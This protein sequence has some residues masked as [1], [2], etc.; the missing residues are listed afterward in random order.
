MKKNILEIYSLAVCFFAVVCFVF[1]AAL[2]VYD[3]AQ[4]I[5][6]GFT[7]SRARFE[8]YMSNEDFIQTS[9]P[10]TA[11]NRAALKML[12]REEITRR[13][14]SELRRVLHAEQ[15]EGKQNLFK[16][17][18]LLLA[19]TAAFAIHWHLAYIARQEMI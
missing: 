6:P 18:I 12:P 16:M 14:L 15:H 13:R 2:A 19:N 10:A 1:V 4:V 5:N 17:L 3:A 11:E 8:R 7:L 9:Q